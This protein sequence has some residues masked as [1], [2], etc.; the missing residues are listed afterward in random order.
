MSDLGDGL[1]AF[2][3]RKISATFLMAQ[4]EAGQMQAHLQRY[5]P[6]QDRTTNARTGLS[7][8]PVWSPG[9]QGVSAR[10]V[11]DLGHSM[12]YGVFLELAHEKTY[13]IVHPTA[14]IFGPK[15]QRQAREIW[16]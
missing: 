12:D 11:V 13:A 14:D 1:K 5:A 15:I 6:W 16:S 2:I 8:F 3:E 7:A 4:N 10:V 9:S